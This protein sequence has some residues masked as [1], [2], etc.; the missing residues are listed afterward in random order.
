MDDLLD[1]MNVFNVTP[2][3][4]SPHAEHPRFSQYKMKTTGSSQEERRKS[5]LDARKM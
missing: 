4:L 1:S 2:Q 5:V 3:V